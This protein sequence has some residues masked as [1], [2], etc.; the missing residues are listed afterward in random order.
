M[1]SKDRR[2]EDFLNDIGNC[3]RCLILLFPGWHYFEWFCE[4]FLLELVSQ[5]TQINLKLF[6]TSSLRPVDVDWN[7]QDEDINNGKY[8]FI[9]ETFLECL[10]SAPRRITLRVT[11]KDCLSFEETEQLLVNKMKLPLAPD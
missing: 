11:F 2:K 10:I 8:S 6:C 3:Y 5:E 7:I 1:S 9:S 4:N